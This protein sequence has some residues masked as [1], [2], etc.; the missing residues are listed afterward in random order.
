MT[1]EQLSCCALI[2]EK[3]DVVPLTIDIMKMKYCVGD[4]TRCARYLLLQVFEMRDIPGELWP[5]DEVKA[6][7]LMEEAKIE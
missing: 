4:K 3:S 1:C 2:R 5:S 7:A 6:L